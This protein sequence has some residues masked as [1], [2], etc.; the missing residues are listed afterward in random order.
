MIDCKFEQGNLSESWTLGECVCA[1]LMPLIAVVEVLMMAVTG[2]FSY[3]PC[4]IIHDHNHKR[5]Y[6]AED[7]A[8]LAHETRCNDSIN[9]T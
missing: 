2:C 9:S 4:T 7:F 8:S 3:C 1:A 6:T 5:T